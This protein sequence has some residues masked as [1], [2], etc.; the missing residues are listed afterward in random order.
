ML[1]GCCYCLH[2]IN[3]QAMGQ[4]VA[5]RSFGNPTCSG[6]CSAK[7]PSGRSE[8][9]PALKSQ[10]PA[11]TRASGHF[12]LVGAGQC[13]TRD[14]SHSIINRGPKPL[15]LGVRKSD[16]NF[17][18]MKNTIPVKNQFLWSVSL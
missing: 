2:I 10:K 6:D 3:L 15:D 1:P 17:K 8:K 11:I 5:F 7:E 12:L 9:M 13:R 16:D 14:H 4:L 18:T